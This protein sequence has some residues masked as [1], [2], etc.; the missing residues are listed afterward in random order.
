MKK[1]LQSLF[2]K[3]DNKREIRKFHFASQKKQIG[4][5]VIFILNYY[6]ILFSKSSNQIGNTKFFYLYLFISKLIEQ[7]LIT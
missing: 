3:Y 4:L 7:I 5:C 6:T 1:D 2:T